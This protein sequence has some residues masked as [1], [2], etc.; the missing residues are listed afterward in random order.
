MRYD[1]QQSLSVV[2]QYSILQYITATSRQY[3]YCLQYTIVYCNTS[4]A[5]R[6]MLFLTAIQY[7]NAIWLSAGHVLYYTTKHHGYQSR[8]FNCNTILQC[9]TTI[10]RV[11]VCSILLYT[12]VDSR[13]AGWQLRCIVVYY[14][15]LATGSAGSRI[16]LQY[17]ITSMP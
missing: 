15:I 12:T 2:L 13:I 17:C 11:P 14:N 16:A 5:Y 9:N 10:T 8:L 1:C 7:N 4:C 6:P 3:T